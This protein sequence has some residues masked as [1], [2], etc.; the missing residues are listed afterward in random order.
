MLDRMLLVRT[1]CWVQPT[2]RNEVDEHKD[3]VAVR[4][5]EVD[6]HKVPAAVEAGASFDGM[7]VPVRYRPMNGPFTVLCKGQTFCIKNGRLDCVCPDPDPAD[8]VH[9]LMSL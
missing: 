3:P 1:N 4:Q 7:S 5:N 8:V 9:K 6:E 2:Q